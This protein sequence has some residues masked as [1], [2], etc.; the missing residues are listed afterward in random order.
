MHAG[1]ITDGYVQ[2][3]RDDLCCGQ[4]RGEA[5]EAFVRTEM[6]VGVAV[7]AFVSFLSACAAPGPGVGAQASSASIEN[8]CINPTEISK[9]TIVSDQEIRFELRNGE[10]W[11][12]RLPYACSGLKIQGGFS[13]EVTGT[14]VCSNQQ[15]IRVKD[16]GTPCMLGEFTR[17]PAEA[18]KA[19]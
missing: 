13:W 2:W 6:K 19:S 4:E 10:I 17:L 11:A 8:S 14:L 15:T 18:A 3:R 16:E 9:Q 7:V 12:N 1:R 5:K